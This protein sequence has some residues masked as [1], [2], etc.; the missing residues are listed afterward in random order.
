RVGAFGRLQPV[1]GWFLTPPH[2]ALFLQ[3]CSEIGPPSAPR[4]PGDDGRAGFSGAANPNPRRTPA[5]AG[6]SDRGSRRTAAAAPRL[7]PVG[8]SR[9][10]NDG[11]PWP[12]S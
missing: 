10:W 4:T 1:F 6:R 3:R 5:V 2:R 9:T 8:R 12:R 7:P 11:P